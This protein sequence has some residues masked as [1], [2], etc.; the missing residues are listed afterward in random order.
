M[1]RTP[2]RVLA[3][4]A[5]LGLL[6]AALVAPAGASTRSQQ[7]GVTDDEIQIVAM[8]ADLDGLRSKGLISQPKLT[9]GNLLKRWQAYADAYGPINGRKV[10]VKSAVWDPI[11]PTTFDKACAS[12]TQDNSPLVVVNGNGYRSASIPCITVDN[13][14]PMIVGDPTYTTNFEASDG[15]LFGLLPPSDVIGKA[16]ANFVTKQ[17]LV[18]KTAKIGILA[19][20][21][22]GQKAG[23]DALAAQLKRNGYNVVSQ[24]ESNV[25]SGDT[26]LQNRESSAAVGTFQA[27]GVD[28][29][30]IGNPFTSTQGYFQEA[31]RSGAS[32]KTF[33]IDGASSMCTIFAAG[34]IPGEAA[35]IPCLTSADTRAVPTKDGVKKDTAAEAQCRADFDKAFAATSQP[36]VPSGDVTAGGVTYSEDFAANECQIMR[37]L[38]PAIKKAG[39]KPTWAKIQANLEKT[40]G[41]AIY[42]S[43]GEG[44]FNKKKHYFADN[45]HLV[46]LNQANAQTA[47]D[48]NGTFNGCPAPVNCWVPQLVNGEEW[49]PIGT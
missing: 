39:K 32:F 8:V 41:P 40:S 31:Q 35:G 34:R 16:T 43:G 25:L 15:R 3:G 4:L 12:A 21:E 24:V 11:D 46:V 14:T 23:T 37:L 28:T 22:P 38:L 5:V 20:N 17:K 1:I 18:P 30:F 27:A 9:T 7:Q 26:A 48:A 42:L 19:S 10:V 6:G 45:L 29:V 44:S 47:K 2:T 36:G 49:F 13:Q 33:V